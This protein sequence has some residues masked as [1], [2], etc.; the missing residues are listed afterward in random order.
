[1]RKQRIAC[2]TRIRCFLNPLSYLP[3][4][5]YGFPDLTGI[6]GAKDYVTTKP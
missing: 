3:L 1:M 6:D 4:Y 5:L 2:H